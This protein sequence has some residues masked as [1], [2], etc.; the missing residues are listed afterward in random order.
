MLPVRRVGPAC[1]FPGARAQLTPGAQ[2]PR[3]YT[4]IIKADA[5]R[6]VLTRY[7]HATESEAP[8]APT[9]RQGRLACR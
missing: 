9:R 4:L 6:A 7:L 2:V 5:C 8:T 3:Q 1:A